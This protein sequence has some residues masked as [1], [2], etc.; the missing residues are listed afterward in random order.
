ME[1]DLHRVEVPAAVKRKVKS[2]PYQNISGV[3]SAADQAAI[4]TKTNEIRA[5]PPV[6]VNLTAEERRA[7]PKMSD[8]SEPFVTKAL[9]YAEANPTLVPP[10]LSVTEWRK[11]YN[12]RQALRQVLQVIQPV[13]ESIGDTELAVGSEA[14]QPVE[15]VGLFGFL[16]V[17]NPS[18]RV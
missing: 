4:T 2:M 15:Q 7:L 3:L 5:L 1:G 17:L 10:F 13:V 9:E 18:R 8:G 6:L 16:Q 12:Y 14:Y 11:D